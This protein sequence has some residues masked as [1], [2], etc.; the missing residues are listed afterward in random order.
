MESYNEQLRQA[1]AALLSVSAEGYIDQAISSE[2]HAGS[3]GCGDSWLP[4]QA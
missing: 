3:A 4:V 2:Q 1:G